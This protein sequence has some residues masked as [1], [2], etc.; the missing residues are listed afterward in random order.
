MTKS[1]TKN[2]LNSRTAK[3]H[4]LT[5]FLPKI[6][7]N[8]KLLN[9]NLLV[10]TFVLKSWWQRDRLFQTH[11][12]EQLPPQMNRQQIGCVT[13]MALLGLAGSLTLA[14]PALALPEAGQ[15][16]AGEA[17]IEQVNPDQMNIIQQSER[18]VIDW[19]S[20]DL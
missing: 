3:T 18:A 9:L 10:S 12:W 7:S 6:L 17:Q 2:L 1:A 8:S 14:K 4:P 19:Q 5:G 13:G 15:V 16:Q 20:F 11:P